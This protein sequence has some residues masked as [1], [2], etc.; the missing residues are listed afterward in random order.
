VPVGARR[1]V[2][3]AEALSRA[4]D[5]RRTNRRA[6]HDAPVP[7]WLVAELQ[8]AAR[9]EATLLLP[10]TNPRHRS[11]LIELNRLADRIEQDDPAYAAE[12]ARWTTDDPRRADGVQAASVPY[13]AAAEE[14]HDALALRGLDPRGMGWLPSSSESGPDQCLVLLCTHDDEPRGWL[15]TGEALER[16][17]LAVTDRGYWASPLSQVIEVRTTH[18]RLKSELG[19]AAEPQLILRIGLAPETVPTRRRPVAEVITYRRSS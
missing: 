9:E 2:P 6:Y 15:R 7:D 14:A 4:I 10:L 5:H 17:W 1:Y 12:I 8:V 18:D 19:L 3:G 16:V 11:V 13:A